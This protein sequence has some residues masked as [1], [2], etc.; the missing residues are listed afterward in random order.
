MLT[1][2]SKIPPLVNSNITLKLTGNL[3]ALPK[4]NSLVF[5]EVIEKKGDN[6]RILINGKVFQSKLPFNVS[7][8][9]QLFA[10]VVSKQPFTLVINDFGKSTV[11]NQTLMANVLSSF[12][13]K[14]TD[15]N[16]SLIDKVISSKKVLGKSK[17]KRVLEYMETQ[18]QKID[19][20][21]LSLLVQIF[22]SFE[23]EKEYIRSEELRKF[24]KIS[25]EDIAANLKSI[26]V[27]LNRLHPTDLITQELNNVFLYKIPFEEKPNQDR[28][29]KTVELIDGINSIQ[30]T[31]SVI[32][33]DRLKELKEN[34]L[35]YLIQKSLYN[36]YSFFPDFMIV[37]KENDFDSVMYF[38]QPIANTMG[39]LSFDVNFS[40]KINS[41]KTGFE[42]VLTHDTIK[43]NIYND[44]RAPGKLSAFLKKWEKKLAEDLQVKVYT[45]LRDSKLKTK[46]GTI[47]GVNKSINVKA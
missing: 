8:G 20:L 39:I 4:E 14:D 41:S 13:I 37:Q 7:E 6:F 24:L 25:F 31:G 42:G 36:Y 1:N 17:F 44:M 32:N 11:P 28:D 38:I 27:E 35:L 22:W 45:S 12:D 47:I 9:E 43:F 26:V 2:I 40:L 46:D 29:K 15:L 30:L 19:D 3:S 34:L 5:M 10:K 16:R 18:D 23:K 33:P 21:Q